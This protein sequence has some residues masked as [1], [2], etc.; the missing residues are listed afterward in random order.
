MKKSHQMNRVCHLVG[1]AANQEGYLAKLK[2]CVTPAG[3]LSLLFCQQQWK[4]CVC[5]KVAIL[6]H[7]WGRT[8][9][10]RSSEQQQ[11]AIS[12]QV[13]FPIE[14]EMHSYISEQPTQL[15]KMAGFIFSYLLYLWHFKREA[16]HDSL[17][18]CLPDSSWQFSWHNKLRVRMAR[19]GCA[20]TSPQPQMLRSVDD[21]DLEISKLD[22]GYKFLL[23]VKQA[24]LKH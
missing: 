1:T 20:M 18:Y 17:V 22:A 6:H 15:I 12:L 9:K 23:K 10:R 5:E 11:Y 21:P 13:S 2:S 24:V 14:K 19:N 16:C 7:C 3:D 4:C 8:L